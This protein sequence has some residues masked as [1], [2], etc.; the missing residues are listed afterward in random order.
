MAAKALC[1][2][3]FARVVPVNP[4]QS[5]MVPHVPGKLSG[6]ITLP[7]AILRALF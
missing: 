1:L 3:S 2:L 7:E 4:G 5:R 6:D